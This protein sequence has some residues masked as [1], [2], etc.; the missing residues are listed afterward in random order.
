MFYQLSYEIVEGR[1]VIRVANPFF[2]FVSS[3][4]LN[5]PLGLEVHRVII[6]KEDYEKLDASRIEIKLGVDQN[7]FDT[8]QVSKEDREVLEMRSYPQSHPACWGMYLSAGGLAYRCYAS[9]K[10]LK[11]MVAVY[12]YKQTLL[13]R[14]KRDGFREFPESFEME[15]IYQELDKPETEFF[16]MNLEPLE[17]EDELADEDEIIRH[18]IE[19][20]EHFENYGTVNGNAETITFL[21][22]HLRT[23]EPIEPGQLIIGD[24][25]ELYRVKERV[26]IHDYLPGMGPAVEH[27]LELAREEGEHV[28]NIGETHDGETIFLES[29]HEWTPELLKT[30]TMVVSK[31]KRSYIVRGMIAVCDYS[32]IGNDNIAIYYHLEK[33]GL[34][35][36]PEEVESPKTINKI[37]REDDNLANPK[38]EDGEV[39]DEADED[40]D[41]EEID[42]PDEVECD[43]CGRVWDGN[44]QCFPCPG[45]YTDSE[46]E[47]HGC[48]K[49]AVES[50]EHLLDDGQLH[51]NCYSWH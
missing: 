26:S 32:S 33:Y 3:K 10:E 11:E 14:M 22:P 30:D 8:T 18:V 13:E 51:P 29:P 31:T 1:R 45:D 7:G 5:G 23:G 34:D 38:W 42:Y 36:V 9:S 21:P 6:S 50:H 24:D 37:S 25:R 15:Q 39:S 46:E 43:R 12:K 2:G 44:A 20:Q 19:N 41:G 28:W 17:P 4:D 47:C 48:E 27:F 35:P 40:L 16:E 49:G